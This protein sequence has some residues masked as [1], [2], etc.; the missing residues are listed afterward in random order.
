MVLFKAL[1]HGVNLIRHSLRDVGISQKRSSKWPKVEK[2]FLSKHPECEACGGKDR[3]NIHH[4]VPFHIDQ[5]LEL[6]ESNL[7]TMCM[8]ANEC[9]LRIAHSGNFRYWNPDVRHICKELQE[10][11]LTLKQAEQVSLTK[12]KKSS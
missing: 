8:G 2:D 9:H 10:K 6:D 3:L 12:L 4:I 5:S 11:K 7:I 1:A